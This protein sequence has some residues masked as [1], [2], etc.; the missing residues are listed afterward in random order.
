LKGNDL[1]FGRKVHI[2][3]NLRILLVCLNVMGDLM[4]ETS[5]QIMA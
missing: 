3:S 5:V 1:K 2:Y 4:N